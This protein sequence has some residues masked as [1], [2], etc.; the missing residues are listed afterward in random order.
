MKD[1]WIL[2]WTFARIGC[3]TFGGGY[4]M[5]PMLQKEIVDKY[6]WTTEEDL[7]DCY[8][9]GQC[10]PGVIAVNTATYIG[11]KQKK[12]LGALAATLGMIFPSLVIIMLIAAVLSNF[13][14]IVA[15]QHAFAGIRIIVAVL[16]I[17]VVIKM[18]K[19]SIK[20]WVGILIF[21][22]AL[23]IGLLFN[24]SPIYT[25]VASALIGILSKTFRGGK[26]I[27]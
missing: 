14:Q 22:M 15:V 25:I 1:L 26:E 11:Y 8:A 12:I 5:L 3:F 4:A 19:T 23:L 2:F 9:I 7:M 16:V 24:L 13:N 18:L 6:H 21:I 27:Q 20:D 17:N 10:T